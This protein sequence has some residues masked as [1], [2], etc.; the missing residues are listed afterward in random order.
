MAPR[1]RPARRKPIDLSR[2]DGH[3]CPTHAVPHD[4][5]TRVRVEGGT[6]EQILAYL[7]HEASRKKAGEGPARPDGLEPPRHLRWRGERRRLGKNEYN[8]AACVKGRKKVPVSEVFVAVWGDEAASDAA[9]WMLVRRFNRK[10]RDW[11]VPLRFRYRDG[12]VT[13]E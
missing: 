10:L 11:G 2:F 13:R 4:P 12:C 9:L 3:A 1:K 6:K 8:F 7:L 5:R